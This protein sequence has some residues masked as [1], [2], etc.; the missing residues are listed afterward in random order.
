MKPVFWSRLDTTARR[1]T[2]FGL[3]VLLVLINVLPLQ[4]PGFAR[5][6][7]LLPLMSIY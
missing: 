3:T 4:M 6:M 5:V 1:L 2:P 7:P